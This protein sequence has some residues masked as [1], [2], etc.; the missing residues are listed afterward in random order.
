VQLGLAPR[1]RVQRAMC[2]PHGRFNNSFSSE[3]VPAG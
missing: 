1:S 3:T 2:Q